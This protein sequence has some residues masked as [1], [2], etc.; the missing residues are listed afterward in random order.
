MALSASDW[1]GRDITSGLHRGVAQSVPTRS[2]VGGVVG[3][4]ELAVLSEAEERVTN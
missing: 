2:P 1:F 3:C 4:G